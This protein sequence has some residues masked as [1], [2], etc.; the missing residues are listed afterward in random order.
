MIAGSSSGGL[1]KSSDCCATA[2]FVRHRRHT[3]SAVHALEARR[4][5][6]NRGTGN[7]DWGTDIISKLAF[8]SGN[9]HQLIDHRSAD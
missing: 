3:R 6:G 5:K 7:R 1:G 4:S 2:P 8:D 9:D